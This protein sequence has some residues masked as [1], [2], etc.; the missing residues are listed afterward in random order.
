MFALGAVPIASACDYG[1]ASGNNVSIEYYADLGFQPV[2]DI[3]LD[4]HCTGGEPGDVFVT[5]K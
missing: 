1:C 2:V 3:V 4:V 5:L